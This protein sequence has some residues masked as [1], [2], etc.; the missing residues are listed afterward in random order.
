MAKSAKNSKKSSAMS[1]QLGSTQ[2]PGMIG[3]AFLLGLL[4]LL[5]WLGNHQNNSVA[6]SVVQISAALLLALGGGIC[7]GL[8]LASNRRPAGKKR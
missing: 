1:Q 6:F 2:V 4:A 8:Q 3:L 7:L 5:P